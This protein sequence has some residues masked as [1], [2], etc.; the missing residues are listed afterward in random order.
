MNTE[1]LTRLA[2]ILDSVPPEQFDLSL[3]R[4]DASCGT[5]AC[6]IGWCTL[7]PEFQ[8]QGFGWDG[9]MP[10]F[11]SPHYFDLLRSWPAVRAFFG[12]TQS[13]VESLFTLNGYPDIED[14]G[15]ADVIDRIDDLLARDARETDELAAQLEDIEQ[16][17][18]DAAPEDDHG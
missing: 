3:W 7:D 10:T 15:T 12:L 5:V 16:A 18:I 1:R 17:Q 13:E 14:P 9:G 8:Q 2:Q 6:A 11:T 4:A